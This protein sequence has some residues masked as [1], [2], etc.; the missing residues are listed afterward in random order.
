MISGSG[1]Q[2]KET[3]AYTFLYC[4]GLELITVFLATVC[5]IDLWWDKDL[6]GFQTIG[7]LVLMFFPPLVDTIPVCKVYFI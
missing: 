5:Q 3:E 6:G 7:R 1:R 4:Y 2:Y